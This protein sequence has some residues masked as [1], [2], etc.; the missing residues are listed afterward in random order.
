MKPNLRPCAALIVAIGGAAAGGAAR[1]NEAVLTQPDRTATA[2]SSAT[3]PLAPPAAGEPLAPSGPLMATSPSLGPSPK[4]ELGAERESRARYA[5]GEAAFKAGRYQQAVLEF[6]AGFAAVPKP[7]F[8]LN[9]GHAYR[10]LGDLHKARAAYKK[11]LLVDPTSDLHEDVL[12][13]IGELDSALA[14]DDRADRLAA[15]AIAAA[16]VPPPLDVQGGHAGLDLSTPAPAAVSLAEEPP[17][18]FYRRAWFWTAVGAVAIGTGIGIYA[19]RGGADE[20]VHSTGSL[21]VLRP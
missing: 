7:G 5:V 16:L 6:E 9:I 2:S 11:F 18:P 4:D 3:T 20:K 21:G 1:A 10:R 15:R 12:S 19:V 8:L 13:L 17:R 14:D